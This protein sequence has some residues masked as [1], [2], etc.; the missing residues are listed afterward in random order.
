MH[1]V[2][3]GAGFIGSNLVH[4][5]NEHG[6]KDLTD[7]R[8]FVNRRDCTISDYLDVTEFEALMASGRHVPELAG[9][10]HQGACSDTTATNGREMMMS[11][12]SFSKRLLEWTLRRGV[13][14]VH[15]S[16]AAVYG[17]NHD[18]VESPE[19]EQPLNQLLRELMTMVV[20][21]KGDRAEDL[22]AFLP[23]PLNQLLADHVANELGPV[24]VAAFL[25]QFLHLIVQGLLDGQAESNQLGHGPVLR[26]GLSSR[27]PSTRGRYRQG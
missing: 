19:H 17:G 4:A 25:D 11:N 12:F 2:T 14:F 13:P 27:R 26:K 5:L 15:A 16:S 9:V 6:Y 20:V 23:P 10:F 7:A 24:L 1:I 18:T 22:L 8:K 21:D 3:G